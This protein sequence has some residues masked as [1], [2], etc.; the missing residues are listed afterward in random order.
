MMAQE[1]RP[2][3]GL[4]VQTLRDRINALLDRAL[5]GDDRARRFCAVQ[6]ESALTDWRRELAGGVTA[7][8][9]TDEHLQCLLRR[10]PR[11]KVLVCAARQGCERARVACA[12][13]LTE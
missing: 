8:T 5:H 3:S 10:S 4:A 9:L 2:V 1:D 13:L 6:I 12:A 11:H 7:A